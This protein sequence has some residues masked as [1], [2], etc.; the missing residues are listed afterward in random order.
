MPVRSIEACGLGVLKWKLGWAAIDDIVEHNKPQRTQ[1]RMAQ[2]FG[3]RPSPGG[4]DLTDIQNWLIKLGQCHGEIP[5]WSM[6]TK[7]ADTAAEKW[8]ALITRHC[9]HHNSSLTNKNQNQT[10]NLWLTMHI[11]NQRHFQTMS[12]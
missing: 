8:R 3:T 9:W 2:C 11:Y 4:S 12:G 1:F 6:L 10:K 7:P 5:E